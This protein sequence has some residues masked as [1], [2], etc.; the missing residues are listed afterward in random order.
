MID[1]TRTFDAVVV[2]GGPA[3]ATAATDLARMG[4]SVL[5][6]DRAGRIKPCG[7]AVPPRLIKEFD[8]P[9]LLLVARINS[10]RMISPA[11]R[12]VDMPIDGGYVGM[13]DRETF[14]EWLRE[15]A[16]SSGATRETGT[17]LG[18]TRDQ[19]GVAIVNFRATDDQ[20]R[21][22]ERQ[23]R[24]R[25]VIGADGA[26]SGVA[27]QCIP[28]ADRIRYVAAYHEIV[29]AP[30]PGSADYDARRCDVYYQGKL[31]PDFYAW[32]FPHGDTVSIGVGSANK[33]FS[34]RKAVGALRAS[35][36][37][38]G[39]ETVRREGAPI[40]LKP[41][42]RWDN[43]RDV[44]LAGDAAGV[45]APASGEGI[46]YAM[47]G[48]R[49][50]AHSIEAFLATGDARQL[51]TARQRFM[52]AHGRVFWVLGLLQRFW[53]TSDRRREQ[54]VK[55][56]KDPDVQQLTWQAYMHKELVRSR[57]MAHV[58]IFFKDL[59]HLVGVARP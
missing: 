40:P 35:T 19:Q 6:L 15:R 54:F 16:A 7:G 8:I 45:V 4:R 59:A 32:I 9:E 12:R 31:S 48:G 58:R 49:L 46:F 50:A 14:D 25:A 11:E 38:D 39:V 18:I 23:V 17:F 37:L 27:Y 30:A 21:P 26:N 10:A 24:A 55:I 43:G 42:G 34:L 41:L 51:R 2:G 29:R 1:M 52:Q 22:C 36:G 56:C 57:P 28:G 53:Y 33:G 13:V 20:G 47:T 3:G 5:L 44:L